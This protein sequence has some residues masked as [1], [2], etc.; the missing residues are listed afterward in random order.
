MVL[1]ASPEGG[2]P[3]LVGVRRDLP[4]RARASAEAPSPESE[5]PMIDSPLPSRRRGVRGRPRRRRRARAGGGRRRRARASSR[6]TTTRRSARAAARRAA[7]AG[8]AVRGRRPSA[9]RPGRSP[10]DAE[11][12]AERGRRGASRRSRRRAPS[13]RSASTITTTSR[14]ATCSRTVFAAQLAAGAASS[15]LPVVIH[16]REATD[17]T[18]AILRERGQG[19]C[20]ACSTASPATSAMAAARA[21]PRLLPL[22]RR[23]R[24]VSRRRTTC[25]R[26]AALVP[27]DRLLIETDSPYLAPVPHRGKRNEPAYVGRVLESLAAVRGEPPADARASRST[28]NFDGCSARNSRRGNGLAR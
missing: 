17:D 7:V 12:A 11:A 24:D 20:A 9:S 25:A 5:L 21:R 22:V 14:R 1:A 28:G 4:R 10:A 18:F 13:A 8:G 3:T 16:T 23:H 2:K 15:R 19:A 27:A 26:S 6:P